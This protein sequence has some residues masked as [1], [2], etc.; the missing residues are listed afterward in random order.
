M[1]R[2]NF[3]HLRICINILLVSLLFILLTACQFNA[4]DLAD[5]NPLNPQST[6]QE[7]IDTQIAATYAA[8]Q[9]RL[10]PTPTST[11]R[12]TREIRTATPTSTV[13][14]TPTESPTPTLLPTSVIADDFSSYTGWAVTDNETYAFGFDKGGYYIF[15]D[16]PGAPVWSA[17]SLD[18]ANVIVE[19]TASRLSGPDD[20][21]FGI[22][23]RQ[24]IDGFNYYI[25]TISIDGSYGIGKVVNGTLHFIQEGMDQAG[26]ILPADSSNLIQATCTDHLLRLK[27]NNQ[28]LLE[29][30]DEDFA[31]GKVG[32]VAGNRTGKG[33]YV[34]FDNFIVQAP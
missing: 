19:T 14:T 4:P 16:F 7:L 34:L 11:I 29:V 31:S 1:P 12:P 32:L 10:A 24:Q 8:E 22:M 18:L 6:P 27:V 21:Y 9:T 3:P 33:L 23:C 5:F 28:L 15:V 26:H 20:G 25:F 30:Q 13:I 17:R 2:K